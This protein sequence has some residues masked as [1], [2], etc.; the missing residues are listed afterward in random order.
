MTRDTNLLSLAGHLLYNGG[1]YC[2]LKGLRLPGRI[3]ALSLEITHRCVCRCIMCNIWKIPHT[4]PELDVNAW[5]DLLGGPSFS[6][7]VELDITGG[8]PF[9]KPGLPDF[10]KQIRNLK[11]VH[12][13]RL[14]SVAITT[15]AV[16][17]RRVLDTTE[18]ILKTLEDTGIQIVLACAMDAVDDRHDR[19]RRHAGA[20]EKM[21][22]TLTGL[23]AL[24]QRFPKLILGIKTTILPD[25]VDQLPAIHD[26]ARRH[27]FF[28]IISPC[29]ITGGRYLNQDLVRVLTFSASHKQQM[30]DFFGRDDLEWGYHAR[31]L[32][33]YLESGRS[34]RRCACGLNYAFIRSTGDV[35]LCPL[36]PET[37]GS[38]RQTDFD[39][40]WR[41]P[42]A[43]RLR[44]QVGHAEPCR[45]CT[46]P[47]L[48]RYSLYYEGWSYLK[49]LL[50]MGGPRFQRFHVHMGLG[51]YFRS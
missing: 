19:I 16:L 32:K 43:R 35:H 51:N 8:E 14:Q 4:V 22:T 17:T 24:R 39:A 44:R 23:L 26:F 18:A 13:R 36:L 48:E 41:S 28:S 29:I 3:E 21:Q 40:I 2:C 27:G 46:E 20:F 49:L 6:D 15:N 38:I 47:G 11:Q 37:V 10:F 25:T 33:D 5:T 45:H 42:A 1:R 7:L 34:R 50:Q 12:L 31:T 9:L 30:I